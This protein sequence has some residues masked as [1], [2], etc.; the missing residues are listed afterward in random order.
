[1]QGWQDFHHLFISRWSSNFHSGL[2]P[3][4]LLKT[5]SHLP[6]VIHPLLIKLSSM[7]L[8]HAPPPPPL[9][10]WAS[11]RRCSWPCWTCVRA[12]WSPGTPRWPGRTHPRKGSSSECTPVSGRWSPGCW[13]AAACSESLPR[14]SALVPGSAGRRKSQTVCRASRLSWLFLSKKKLLPLVL[15]SYKPKNPGINPNS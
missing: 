7:W 8:F 10:P 5:T 4:W 6:H 2:M 14:P 9:L 12:L 11:S 13:S 1:M 15:K 3:L